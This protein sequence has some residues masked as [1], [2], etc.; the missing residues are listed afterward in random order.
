MAHNH[1]KPLL[2]INIKTGRKHQIRK[3][4]S[5]YGCPI[6]GDRLYNKTE[7]VHVEDLRP[8][9]I[10]LKFICPIELKGNE[11]LEFK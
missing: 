6:I 7:K 2:E 9:A 8:Q 1:N 11:R 5:G 10:S 4:L 3:H